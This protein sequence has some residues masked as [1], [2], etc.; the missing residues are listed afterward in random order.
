MGRLD[1]KVALI[2]GGASGVGKATARSFVEEGARV[3]ISDILDD[4]GER[5]VQEL[6][7]NASYLHTD[8]R[9]EADVET[10]VSHTLATFGRLD[11]LFNSVDNPDR[12]GLVDDIPAEEFDRMIAV[13]LR[14]VFFSMKHVAAVMKRQGGGSIIN[15]TSMAGLRTRCAGH[16]YSAAK[17]AVIHLTRSVAM[18]LGESGVRANCICVDSAPLSPFRK[19]FGPATETG[20]QIDEIVKAAL[21]LASD[22]SRFVVNGHVLVVDGGQNAGHMISSNWEIENQLRSTKTLGI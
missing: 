17:A 10:A 3:V 12:L 6:A 2:T 4:E 9:R 15:T 7:A 11:C 8:I 22:D 5:L 19:A 13:L 16:V 20:E 21:W 14:G 1:D 18:E